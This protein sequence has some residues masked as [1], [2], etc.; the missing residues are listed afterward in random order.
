M[1]KI[2]S[3]WC[4]WLCTNVFYI[5]LLVTKNIIYTIFYGVL[6]IEKYSVIGIILFFCGVLMIEDIV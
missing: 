3:V 2:E 6:K 4:L 1:I 5:I